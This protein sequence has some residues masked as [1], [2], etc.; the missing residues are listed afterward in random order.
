MLWQGSSQAYGRGFFNDKEKVETCGCPLMYTVQ[1]VNG[2]ME[3]GSGR[4]LLSLKTKETRPWG[5]E[6]KLE[7]I[8]V[9]CRSLYNLS[10][11]QRNRLNRSHSI[12]LFMYFFILLFNFHLNH[13]KRMESFPFNE[14]KGLRK[15]C[16]CSFQKGILRLSDCAFDHLSP[17][18]EAQRS[19]LLPW[20]SAGAFGASRANVVIKVL[21]KPEATV[22]FK[23]KYFTK[24]WRIK[25]CGFG[26]LNCSTFLAQLL[27]RNFCTNE[28]VFSVTE[29][30]FQEF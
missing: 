25:P 16:I 23:K 24:L 10:P 15:I 18:A 19:C 22:W 7:E 6:A 1:T 13:S 26:R 27:E 9:V 21:G 17:S 28:S 5:F 20:S 4:S 12:E 14:N 8:V 29:M 2:M 30:D 3:S 11:R